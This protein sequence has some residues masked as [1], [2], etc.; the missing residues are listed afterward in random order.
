MTTLDLLYI[1][2]VAVTLLL[3]HFVLWRTF[4]RRAQH[5]PARAR[6]KLWC[7][8]MAML[9]MLAVVGLVLWV[10]EH[11]IWRP[12]GFALPHGWRLLGAIGL[13]LAIGLI[14]ARSVG[15]LARASHSERARLR[16][17]FGSLAAMLPHSG[18]DLRVF[19]PLSI[20][21]GFCEEFI[22]RGYLVWAFRTVLGLWGAAGLSVLA[23]AAG[24]AYQG[25]KGVASAA[26]LGAL[27]TL[28]VLGFGSLWPAIALHAL[29]DITGGLTAWLGF[30]DTHISAGEATLPM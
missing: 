9:W 1:A 2:F 26:I 15:R 3:D 29:V 27:L 20:T 11:R 6:L 24:H 30:R 23:F 21:A 13:V 10:R 28:V 12:V 19:I 18:S 17:K 14:Q 16:E 22:F 4:L 25:V 8:W 7:G 5:D